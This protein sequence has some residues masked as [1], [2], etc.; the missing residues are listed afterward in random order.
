MHWHLFVDVG[1]WSRPWIRSISQ[2][3]QP[4]GFSD[5]VTS[6]ARRIVAPD[7]FPFPRQFQPSQLGTWTIADF[8]LHA[9][10]GFPVVGLRLSTLFPLVRAGLVAL[11]K[12]CLVF[13]TFLS[14]LPATTTAS[15]SNSPRHPKTLSCRRPLVPLLQD[16]P[17][18][19]WRPPR[20]SDVRSITVH[21]RCHADSLRS[22]LR[23]TQL[24]YDMSSWG[25]SSVTT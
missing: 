11:Q 5:Q 4:R 19:R 1:G 21:N 13:L 14:T 17:V 15:S 10:T 24:H 7:H 20:L 3:V 6:V 12:Q 25:L 2:N 23:R 16:G 8:P 9:V 18:R 22:P